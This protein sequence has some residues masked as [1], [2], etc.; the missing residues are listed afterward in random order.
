MHLFL[1]RSAENRSRVYFL[2]K[3]SLDPGSVCSPF[4]ETAQT[5]IDLRLSIPD[6]SQTLGFLTIFHF[7]QSGCRE[8]NPAYVHPMHAYC[9]YTTARI[10]S[11]ETDLKQSE[12][13]KMRT[14]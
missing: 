2:T 8:S 7:A 13:I 1:C 12:D 3:I 14:K 5:H 11:P 10:C 4:T 6:E 9:R